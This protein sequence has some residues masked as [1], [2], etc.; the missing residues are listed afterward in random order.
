M[1]LAFKLFRLQQIDSQLDRANRRLAEIVSILEDDS[2]VRAATSELERAQDVLTART[3]ELKRAEGDTGAQRAKIKDSESQ[4]Y[5]GHVTNPKELQD[6]QR[7]IEALN[8]HLVVLEDRQLEAM[9]AMET[10]QEEMGAARKNK[11][12]LDARSVEKNASLLGE[13]T[14]LEAD[15]NRLEEERQAAVSSLSA[16]EIDHYDRLRSK[17]MGVAVAAV[18]DKTCA[19]CGSTLS[20][21]LLQAAQ[22]PNE[23]ATCSS[24]GRILYGG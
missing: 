2:E 24:C 16:D 7:E 20:A 10:A 9:I 18:S 5:G 6:L 17:K 3:L 11:T 13:Q 12:D 19:A 21:A 15:V 23:I 4:L 14:D 1:N 8:R 22:S